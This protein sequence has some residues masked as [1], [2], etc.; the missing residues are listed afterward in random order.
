MALKSMTGFGAATARTKQ[1]SVAVEISSVNRRQLDVVLR[2][3]PALA[4]FEMQ[5]QKIVQQHISRG[6]V[7]GTV[8]MERTCGGAAVT[9]DTRRAEAVVQT[10]RATAKQLKLEDDLSASTLLKIPGLLDAP[11]REES[12]ETGPDGFQALE[13]ALRS[14]LK[15]LNTMR[16]AE[17]RVLEADLLKRL[18]GL[19]EIRARIETRA[20]QVVSAHRKKIFQTLN[21]LK[22]DV[23]ANDERVL[24]EVALFAERSDMSEEL[25]RLASHIDQFKK[26]MRRRE[27]SG[28][29]LDFLSQELLREINTIASKAN[30]LNVTKQ[31]VQFKT[32]LE[33]IREQVQNAE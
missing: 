4:A 17:G 7:N 21:T 9:I 14:A 23:P 20:P 28:R 2:L 25:T 8:K 29:A 22:L 27:P 24:K 12:E 5:A 33:R 32:E 18:E 6:R 31:A 10:L 13:K 30:D 11:G 26:R 16:A 3:P 15:K 19:E 1:V